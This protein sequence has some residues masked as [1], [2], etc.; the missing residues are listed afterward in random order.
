MGKSKEATLTRVAGKAEALL[1]PHPFHK[2]QKDEG[3]QP[4]RGKEMGQETTKLCYPYVPA[5]Y[6]GLTIESDVKHFVR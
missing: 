2:N 6:V 4:T 1:P 3:S 5:N